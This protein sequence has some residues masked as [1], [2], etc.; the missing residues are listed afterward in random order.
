MLPPM[1]GALGCSSMEHDEQPI[2]S[3]IAS[4]QGMLTITVKES[5]TEQRWILAGPLT[6]YSVA[7]V[8][9]NWFV[10]KVS[11]TAGHRVVDLDGLSV[12]DSSGERA[13]SMM[14]H[15]G[16]KFGGLYARHLL[17]A[18]QVRGGNTN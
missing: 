17:W 14:I 12:I 3:Q 18:L 1:S 7:E 2:G 4:D 10:S 16:A 9:S 5:A 6:D 15:D 11:Q 8:L 13:L